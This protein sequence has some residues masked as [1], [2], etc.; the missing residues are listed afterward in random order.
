MNSVATEIDSWL[1]SADVDTAN[2]DLSDDVWEAGFEV[3]R[4]VVYSKFG[5][6][7]KVFLRPQSF[8]KRFFH[9]VYPLSIEEWNCTDSVDLYDGFCTIDITLDVRFQATYNYALS[10]IELLAELNE[11]IKQ[12]YYGTVTDIVNRELLNLSD[13]DWVQEGLELIEKRICSKINEMLI[14]QNIQSQVT[15]RLKPSFEEFP[16]VQFA[17]EKVYLSVLK[18]SFEFS[19]QQREELFRQQQDEKNQNIDHKRLQLEQINKIAELD[20]ERTAVDAENLKLLLSEKEQ[21]Q[22]EQFVIRKRLHSE[23]VKHNNSLKE[24]T[25]SA[26]LEEKEAYQAKL[27]E[28]EEQEKIE[29]IAHETKL[30]EKELEAKIAEFEK[31]Q[32]SWR[33]TKSKVHVEE[34]EL[35]QQQKQ[36]EFDTD[37]NAKKR[38]ELRRLAM[39]KESFSVRKKADIYLKREIE[40]L[41]LDK[42][43]LALQQTIKKYKDESNQENSEETEYLGD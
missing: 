26:E 28:K 30:K 17:K 27:R 19:E 15:C 8:V 1:V 32:A 41:E 34:L 12:A 43:R 36:I 3:D 24:M 35:K 4:Q 20:R 42:Q 10:N 22:R 21:H 5:A 37:V 9:T 13:G 16:D 11:H 38:Y 33:E 25:L 40:L 23:K 14:L 29:L 18:K 6:Y 7:K 2:T 31:E 39:Q